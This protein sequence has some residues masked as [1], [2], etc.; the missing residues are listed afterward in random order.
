MPLKSYGYVLA[1]ALEAKGELEAYDAA[2]I[3]IP[4]M[5]FLEWHVERLTNPGYKKSNTSRQYTHSKNMTEKGDS[6]LTN[7]DD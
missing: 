5:Y 2:D 4:K 6:W 1:H 3:K 7:P